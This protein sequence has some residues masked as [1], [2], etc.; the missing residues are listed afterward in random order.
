MPSNSTHARATEATQTASATTHQ[1]LHQHVIVIMTAA[2]TMTQKMLMPTFWSDKPSTSVRPPEEWKR[3]NSTMLRRETN[4]DNNMRARRRLSCAETSRCTEAASL[5][6]PAH[7]PMVPTNFRRRLISQATSWPS[8]A[9]NFIEMVL[10]S[11]ARDANSYTVSMTLRL[12]WLTLKPSRKEPDLPNR[13]TLKSAGTRWLTACGPTW[14]L[15]MAAVHQRSQDLLASN[16][17]TTKT[18]SKRTSDKSNKKTLLRELQKLQHQQQ[19]KVQFKCTT[20]NNN[21]WWWNSTHST[22][23]WTTDTKCHNHNSKA[24][25]AST[26]T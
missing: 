7:M 21:Q 5:V 19:P 14:R 24:T 13:E 25:W 8:F 17:F 15:V 3:D 6:T 20:T 1:L 10:A 16:K 18:P 9:L 11:M 22:K 2:S 23:T 26:W 4:S 12:N